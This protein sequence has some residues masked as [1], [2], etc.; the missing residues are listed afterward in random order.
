MKI[1]KSAML[2]SA[3]FFFLQSSVFADSQQIRRD[4][5]L[6]LEKEQNFGS[7][8]LDIEVIAGVVTARGNVS[9]AISKARVSEIAESL[10]GV[11]RVINEVEVV[12]TEPGATKGISVA[13]LIV[14]R[15]QRELTKESYRLNV[16]LQGK[17]VILK[18]TVDTLSGARK[19]VQIAESTAPGLIVK[20]QMLVKE[21]VLTDNELRDRV[22]KA[23]ALDP[24]IQISDLIIRAENGIVHVS[25]SRPEHRSIDRI[26]STV[27][28]V[29][30]VKDVKSSVV[31]GQK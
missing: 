21:E 27:I 18:G 28:M 2:V 23:L 6:R 11:S 10:K 26:L 1:L 5:F 19:I 13:D 4:F 3:L 20:N 12:P 25:G 15:T 31:I 9:S 24:Q 16:A 8:N 17:E 30:G 29:E 7:Y 22:L 14:E